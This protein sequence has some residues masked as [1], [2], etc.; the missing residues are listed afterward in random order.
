MAA[1]GLVSYPAGS[2][3]EDRPSN[4]KGGRRGGGKGIHDPHAGEVANAR[5]VRGDVE[6]RR[7]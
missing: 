3:E 1:R 7:V 6:E 5:L 4:G 2:A